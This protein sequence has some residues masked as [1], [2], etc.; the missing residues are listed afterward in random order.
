MKESTIALVT[1]VAARDADEDLAPLEL[2][3]RDAGSEVTIAEWDVPRDWH[4]F[5]MVLLRSPWDYPQ[6]LAEFLA[7]AE[8]V[9]CKTQLLNPFPVV[10]WNSDKHY[11]GDL[12]RANVSTVPTKFIEPGERADQR[13][14]E[15]LSQ[16]DTR[17][18]VVKPAVGGGSRDARRF[19]RDDRAEAILHAGRMLNENRGVLL[20][21]YLSRVD[22]YG[23]TALIYFDGEFSH[24]IRKGP[25]LKRKE[26]PPKEP[27]GNETITARV[28]D[29]AELRVAAT[30]LK[31]IPFETPLYARVDL[32][33][34]PN[35]DPVVLELELLEPSLFFASSPGSVDRFAA[36]VRKRLPR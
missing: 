31:A 16:P 22:E 6:R 20:Q 30:A 5:D 18:F 23:E 3:L 33:R 35:G 13:I 27:F 9:S 11:L 14:E 28:P 19:G 17:E 36:A 24:A 25:L 32:I 1:A 26:G 12:S 34:D 7:W 4:R 21:P 29:S 15:L 8:E 10:K 2:T